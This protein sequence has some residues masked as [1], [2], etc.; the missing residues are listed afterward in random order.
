MGPSDG[1]GGGGGVD[2]S[3]L[4]LSSPPSFALQSAIWAPNGAQTAPLA[5]SGLAKLTFNLHQRWR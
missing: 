1:R 3:R 4:F 2:T 5:R